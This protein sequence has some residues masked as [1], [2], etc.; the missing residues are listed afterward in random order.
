MVRDLGLAV[1]RTRL[2]WVGAH[3]GAGEST[4]EELFYGTRAAG[5]A[6]PV[7]APQG[8]ASAAV[9]VART[10]ARG[11]QAVQHAL[12]QREAE[13]LAVDVVGLV[14]VADAPGRLPRAL[15]DLVRHV[16]AAAPRVWSLP[17]VEAWRTGEPPTPENA[18]R[19]AAQLLGELQ[20]AT[21]TRS[22]P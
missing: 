20:Q 11:L 21:S 1:S 15:R 6:W 16:G 3:G 8:S 12:R 18:P 14:L 2:W 9:V 10:S 4:L 19:G 22:V 7:G 5:H 13:Q 17:W